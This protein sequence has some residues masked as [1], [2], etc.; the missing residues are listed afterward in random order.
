MMAKKELDEMV[1]QAARDTEYTYKHLRQ[2]IEITI[3]DGEEYEDAVTFVCNAAYNKTL[4]KGAT[5]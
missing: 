1:K 4:W 3:E 2:E 5:K